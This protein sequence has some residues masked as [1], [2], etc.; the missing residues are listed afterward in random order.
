MRNSIKALALLTLP[1]TGF[2]AD[3]VTLNVTGSLHVP[4][5]CNVTAASATVA[6]GNI[7]SSGINGTANQKPLG[8]SVACSSRNPLQSVNVQVTGT[9]TATNK[10]PITGAAKGF[11]LALKKGATAQ[12]FGS[13]IPMAA[14]GSIDLSLT[15]EVKSGEAFVAGAFTAALTV[16]VTVT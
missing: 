8:V 10:L 2:A 14:D 3:T 13:N 7:L 4:T 6:F 9:G 16:K 12:N 11:V 1:V 15:P 5:V